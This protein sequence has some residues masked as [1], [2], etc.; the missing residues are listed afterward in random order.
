MRSP[1]DHLPLASLLQYLYN[2]SRTNVRTVV[3]GRF[4]STGCQHD[5]TEILEVSEDLDGTGGGVV[6]RV[7]ACWMRG[8]RR[9]LTERGGETTEGE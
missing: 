7:E 5:L 4:M 2:A 1:D 9:T 6:I 3:W 8:W